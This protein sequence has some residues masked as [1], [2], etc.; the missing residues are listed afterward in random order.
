MHTAVLPSSLVSTRSY[1]SWI[2]IID[3]HASY[4]SPLH[5]LIPSTPITSIADFHSR[6]K[7]DHVAPIP[8]TSHESPVPLSEGPWVPTDTYVVVADRREPGT[9]ATSRHYSCCQT[10]RTNLNPRSNDSIS[11]GVND[12]IFSVAKSCEIRFMGSVVACSLCDGCTSRP[13]MVRSAFPRHRGGG[14]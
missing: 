3:H 9:V 5:L 2:P 1:T 14:V 11:D 13:Y 7:I 4:L 10:G 6:G 8:A 12:F